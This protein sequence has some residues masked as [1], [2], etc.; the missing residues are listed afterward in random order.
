MN[1]ME[2]IYYL[3]MSVDGYIATPDGGVD[4]L[5]PFQTGDEDYGYASFYDS[6]DGLLFGRRTYE[7]IVEFG[8]WPYLEKPSWVLSRRS[9]EIQHPEVTLTAKSSAQVVDE[10]LSRHVK[11]VW[12]VGGPTLA[13][14][15]REARLIQA[16][17]ITILPVI[18]GD[19]IRLLLPA[20]LSERLELHKT[21]EFGQ[22]VIQLQYRPIDRD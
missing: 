22:G 11:R 15:F 8:T 12:L 6:V 14:S 7:Q 16:Y 17:I 5:I 20:N 1:E 13:A 21:Q 9:I 10:L 3:A 18:L 19:G 4:W 2:I